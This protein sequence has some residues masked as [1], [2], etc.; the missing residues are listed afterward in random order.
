[1]PKIPK[2]WKDVPGSQVTEDSL[3][4]ITKFYTSYTTKNHGLTISTDP[5]NLSGLNLKRDS[6]VAAPHAL[7]IAHVENERKVMEK[8]IKKKAPVVRFIFR[9]KTKRQLPKKRC[10]EIK[11]APTTYNRVYSERQRIPLRAIVKALKRD[12]KVYRKDLI[13]IA[14]K[15]LFLLKDFKLRNKYANLAESKKLKSK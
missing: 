2:P 4:E 9:V 10:V 3:W 15:K 8:K 5:L 6:G 1:M 11:K 14:M 13:P 12:L 7:G